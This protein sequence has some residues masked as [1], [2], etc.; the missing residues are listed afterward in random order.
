[1][2]LDLFLSPLLLRLVGAIGLIAAGLLLYRLAN[3]L[4]LARARSHLPGL[5]DIRDGVPLLVYFTTPRRSNV[6]PSS[7]CRSGWASACR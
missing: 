2:H 3:R 1:M 6:L 7:A 5:Y 4:I